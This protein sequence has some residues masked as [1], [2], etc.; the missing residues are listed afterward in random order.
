MHRARGDAP[1]RA[2]GGFE[3]HLPRAAPAGACRHISRDISP[4]AVSGQTRE[5]ELPSCPSR[6]A[7]TARGGAFRITRVAA[8]CLRYVIFRTVS[9]QRRAD[10]RAVHSPYNLHRAPCLSDHSA[11]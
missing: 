9:L 3:L 6:L 8:R 1:L 4:A 11:L 2:R 7:H 10:T 5:G